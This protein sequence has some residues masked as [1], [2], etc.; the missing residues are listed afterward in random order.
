MEKLEKLTYEEIN[1]RSSS[2]NSFSYKMKLL[3]A[4][5]IARILLGEK[6][7]QEEYERKKFGLDEEI[8]TQ[9]IVAETLEKH[10]NK[11]RKNDIT[12]LAP[13]GK[14]SNMFAL[15]ALRKYRRLL[16]QRRVLESKAAY[17]GLDCPANKK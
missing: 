1:K 11:T 15:N 10:F 4:K 6:L 9:E 13:I 3:S 8:V 5:L 16:V 17:Y 12:Y 2:R 14:C 7:T